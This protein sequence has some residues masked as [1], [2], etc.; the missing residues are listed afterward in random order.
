MSSKLLKI[1]FLILLTVTVAEVILYLLIKTDPGKIVKNA[2]LDVEPSFRTETKKSSK[3]TIEFIRY[4][5]TPQFGEN[6]HF[7]LIR[8][9][10]SFHL[11]LAD[12]HAVFYLSEG[13]VK[14][15]LTFIDMKKFVE[16]GIIKAGDTAEFTLVFKYSA[17]RNNQTLDLEE[18][19]VYK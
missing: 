9:G 19:I 5:D 6:I 4:Q 8:S 11:R 15:K 1:I 7:K 3:D 2:I 13:S 17:I 18:L 16:E 10:M 12:P 14:T